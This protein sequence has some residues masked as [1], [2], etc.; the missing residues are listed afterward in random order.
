M[1]SSRGVENAEKAYEEMQPYLMAKKAADEK[2]KTSGLNFSIVRPGKLTE[3]PFTGKIEIEAVLNQRGEISRE[4][5]A[6]VLIHMLDE[7]I[8]GKQI[9][10]ILA[11]DV[12]I[13]T[14]V[15]LF[16]KTGQ[17]GV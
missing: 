15:H 10:G 4:D 1:L 6:A 9:F 12:E 17:S 8:Q 2:L 16:L 11:G 5:V 3:G 14:A 7:K 13:A